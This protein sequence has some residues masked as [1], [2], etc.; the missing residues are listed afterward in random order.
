MTTTF[1]NNLE[2]LS[3]VLT[4]I[5]ER[6]QSDLA[7]NT[8]RLIANIF[9]SFG[10]SIPQTK[11][12]AQLR[13]LV[14]QKF[15]EWIV[16]IHSHGAI[17]RWENIVDPKALIH[18]SFLAG[19]TRITTRENGHWTHLRLWS[20]VRDCDVD[21]SSLN[22]VIVEWWAYTKIVESV[23]ERCTVLF[24]WAKIRNSEIGEMNEIWQ[25]EL[26][27]TKTGKNMKALH[28]SYL[29]DT[30]VGDDVNIANFVG[31]MNS[32]PWWVKAKTII[33]DNVFTWWGCRIVSWE[34]GITIGNSAIIWAGATVLCDIP[35]HHTYISKDKIYPNKSIE[36]ILGMAIED[37]DFWVRLYNFL[38]YFKIHTIGDTLRRYDELLKAPWF[39][40]MMKK[41]IDDFKAK[42]GLN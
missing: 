20:Y 16:S 5:E 21:D 42:N 4:S 29:W 17:M 8:A 31:V 26:V 13:N 25:G 32:G 38:K 33:W 35:S 24:G 15:E 14:K 40:P 36:K 30:E 23:V 27:R 11:T 41:E 39:G 34:R 7:E 6:Y 3:T 22:G 9:M 1:T 28:W 2:T 10:V 37:V 19:N 18:W 12:F